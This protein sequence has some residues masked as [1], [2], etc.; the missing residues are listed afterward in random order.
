MITSLAGGKGI[1]KIKKRDGSMV[2]GQVFFKGG[3][4]LFLLWRFIVFTFRNYLTLCKIVLCIWKKTIFSC[5]HNFMKKVILSCLKMNLKR[6]HT[7]WYIVKQILKIENWFLIE[8]DS[9]TGIKSPFWYLL[10]PVNYV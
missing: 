6:S 3:R 9:W 2:Q 10:K 5:H 4:A 8:S 7:T 1:W